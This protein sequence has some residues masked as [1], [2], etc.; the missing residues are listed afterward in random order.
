MLSVRLLFVGVGSIELLISYKLF[1][2]CQSNMIKKKFNF[3]NIFSL[4]LQPWSLSF[5]KEIIIGFSACIHHE[6][7]FA[8]E[9]LS[10]VSDTDEQSAVIKSYDNVLSLLKNHFLSTVIPN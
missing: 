7:S 8:R 4:I 2:V 5:N 10:H 1:L 6:K 3:D 9:Y